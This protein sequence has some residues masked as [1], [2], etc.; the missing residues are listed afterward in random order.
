MCKAFYNVKTKRI[1]RS[2][3]TRGIG[4]K[5]RTIKSRKSFEEEKKKFNDSKL[6]IYFIFDEIVSKKIRNDEKR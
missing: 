1:Y 3:Y 5:D 2:E 6:V 4:C